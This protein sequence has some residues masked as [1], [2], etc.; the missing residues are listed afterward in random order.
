MEIYVKILGSQESGYSGDKPNQRGKYI[1]IPQGAYSAF[2][3]LSTTVLNDTKIIKA[4]TI[5]GATIGLN[6]VYHNAK[7]FPQILKR[8][9]N[10][11]RI[12]RNVALDIDLSL[13]RGVV[14]IMAKTDI[15]EYAID[16]VLPNAHDYLDWVKLAKKAKGLYKYDDLKAYARIK[17]LIN[18][19]K[20]INDDIFNSK[21]VIDKSI[22]VYNKAREQQPAIE[23]DPASILSTLIKSQSD[24]AKYLR[25]MYGNKCA[26][27]NT[28]LIGSNPTGLDAAH[29]QAHT[30]KGP[31]LPSNGM[32][33]SSDLHSCF[34][35]GYFGLTDDNRIIIRGDVPK[36]SE[37]YHFEGMTIQPIVGFELFSPYFKY[38]RFHREHHQILQ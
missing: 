2:P 30:H 6:I 19:T 13:D 9:H 16:S 29:I 1:L 18:T 3:V 11:V 31:L 20:N 8:D 14:V 38:S 33:L 4:R 17:S 12:Y 5:S 37:L 26:M 35:K 32:L 36:T 10:E 7:Y 28:S 21:E 27:R 23:G 25:D 34:D 15:G 22:N 24:F